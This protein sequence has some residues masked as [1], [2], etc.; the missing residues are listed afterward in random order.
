MKDDRTPAQ[1]Y[2]AWLDAVNIC[3]SQGWICAFKW[4]FMSP[5]GTYHDLSGADLT[6]L[7]YIEANGSFLV[8]QTA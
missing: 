5:S 4:V 8:S 3:F 6:R 7:S 1:R 2:K